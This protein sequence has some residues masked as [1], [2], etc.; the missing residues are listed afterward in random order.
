MKAAGSPR[1]AWRGQL[2]V[3]LL[4]VLLLT[5]FQPLLSRHSALEAL[6]GQALNWRFQ[7]RGPQAPGG[8]VVVLAIDDATLDALGQ[9]PLSRAV[10]AEALDLLAADGARVVA[11]DLLFSLPG[12]AGQS[13]GQAATPA[14][15]D[16]IAF[17]QAIEDFGAVIVPFAFTFDEARSA[18]RPM[19]ESVAGSAYRVFTLSAAGAETSG[20]VPTGVLPPNP[21]LAAPA[22]GAHVNLF[23]D[24]DG[25][26]RHAQT[27]IARGEAYYPGLPLEAVRLFL[28]VAHDSVVVQVGRGVALGDRAFATDGQLR[29]VV[30][31]L[32]PS[33][34][35]PTYSLADLLAG[36]I[37]PGSFSDRIV[38][39]GP[40]ALAT[41]GR[42]VSPFTRTLPAVE[43]HAA[44]IDNMLTDRALVRP[45]WS[46]LF[47][48]A[49]TVVG[50]LLM[51][52]VTLCT[53]PL[54]GAVGLLALLGMWAGLNY[55]LFAQFNLW[56][57]F[58]YPALAIV[59]TFAALS[60]VRRLG[61]RR[62]HR[63]AER[64]RRN[65]S[66]F[67]PAALA[68]ALADRDRPQFDDHVQPVAVMFLDMVAS[69]SLSE[70]MTPGEAMVLL[71]SF[72]RRVEQA[73]RAHNGIVCQFVGDG[74]MA[75]FGISGPSPRDACDAIA[76]ARQ[77]VLDMAAWSRERGAQGE[78][79]V[80]IAIG[81][82]YGPVAIGEIGGEQQ[83]QFTLTGDIV[84]VAS[85]LEALTRQH[86]TAIIA[87]A[88][89]VAAA[90]ACDRDKLLANFE[91]LPPQPIRGR[92]DPLQIW[93]WRGASD[94]AGAGFGR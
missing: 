83:A 37:A 8:D 68:S 52:I 33:G 55:L 28:G 36:R 20:P 60:L 51:A 71:R 15:E 54:G 64:R 75:G 47:D 84:N 17:A 10:L 2:G 77:L 57:A 4:L 35:L 27:V 81:L 11:F 41:G 46:L 90:Q 91:E 69:T 23:L 1:P 92:E 39:I 73:V 6:E 48:L 58:V 79:Q 94:D 89:L 21:L 45:D 76:C 22:A 26:L 88:T 13:A 16:D 50:S 3:A 42:F 63:D 43:F 9:W 5:A 72:H 38:V 67:V 82:H 18:E 7:L 53:G 12:Q 66:R 49:A 19:P 85:R 80:R 40:T 70:R 59:I 61:D 44:V 78:P 34:S 56:L 14:A 74:A 30:N 31:H 86:G 29:L 93:A 62:A 25:S 87:S 24:H 65:L 32:G